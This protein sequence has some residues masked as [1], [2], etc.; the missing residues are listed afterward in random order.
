MLLRGERPVELHPLEDADEDHFELGRNGSASNPQKALFLGWWLLLAHDVT[1]TEQSAAVDSLSILLE[2]SLGDVSRERGRSVPTS[3]TSTL[4]YVVNLNPTAVEVVGI[5]AVDAG[6]ARHLG[7]S[8]V[9][10][11]PLVTVISIVVHP[12]EEAANGPRPAL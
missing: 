8:L 5:E 1:A 4:I 10:R 12:A 6:L 2:Q 11:R 3:S 7:W 9:H